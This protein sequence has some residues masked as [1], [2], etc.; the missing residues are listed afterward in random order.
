MKV[1]TILFF[2]F[3]CIQGYAVSSGYPSKVVGFH[4]DI[5]KNNSFFFSKSNSYSRPNTSEYVRFDLNI[6]EAGFY[7]LY[8]DVIAQNGKENSFFVRVNDGSVNKWHIPLSS[9]ETRRKAVSKVFLKK[10][11]NIIYFYSRESYTM[12]ADIA[13]KFLFYNESP[14]LSNS[15]IYNI[16][17]PSKYRGVKKEKIEGNTFFYGERSSFDKNNLN[18]FIEFNVEVNDPGFYSLDANM[19]A[20]DGQRNSF[21]VKVNNRFAQLWS[22]G[23]TTQPSFK[24]V[25]SKLYLP[26]G[27]SKIVFYVREKMTKIA[28]LKLSFRSTAKSSFTQR[29]TGSTQETRSHRLLEFVEDDQVIRASYEPYESGSRRV[30][31]SYDVS[32]SNEYTLS[33][34]VKF[35]KNFEFVKGGK[36]HGVGPL[37]K[38]T[39]CR[40]ES[41]EGWSSRVMFGAEG[42]VKL[43]LYEQDRKQRC[44][45]GVS[46]ISDFKFETDRWYTV[47][48]YTKLNSRGDRN[49]GTAKLY[50][51]GVQLAQ[52]DNLRFRG[53]I[54]NNTEIQSFLFSTFH[55]GSNESWS[56][57]QTVKANFDDF[58]MVKGDYPRR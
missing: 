26:R 12:I 28:D 34:R 15:I 7:D 25:N 38:T 45:R 9:K 11:K 17:Y 29:F 30:L 43:Y 23:Y 2:S 35:D 48:I 6:K 42:R 55:G 50:I 56:P 10:G 53:V 14:I 31:Y 51:D 4:K 41:K 46:T 54:N 13:A 32:R 52:A 33:Y 8:A 16:G 44:G 57:S 39:G 37:V 5:I 3:L 22:S 49:D 27:K 18:D 19:I 40:P 36:L 24:R 20:P 47:S 21:Y 1:L 58:V